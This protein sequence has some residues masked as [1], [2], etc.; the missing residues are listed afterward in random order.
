[1]PNPQFLEPVS[2]DDPCGPD[3]RWDADFLALDNGLSAAVAQG[4][5]TVVAGQVVETA[6]RAYD[7]LVERAVALSA[8]TKDLRVLATYAEASWRHGGLVAFAEAMEDLAG[9]VQQWPGAADG[10]HPRAD[11]IDG[12]LGERA[13]ALGK[14]LHQIPVLVPTVGWGGHAS[15]GE[16]LQSAATLR[17]V[18]DAWT[19]RMGGAFG[20]ELPSAGDAWSSLRR[21]VGGVPAADGDADADA[22]AVDGTVSPPPVDA[23]D[24]IDQAL[25]RM[26]DQDHHSPALPLLRMLSSWRSLG[27]IDIVDRMK[28]SGVTLE[29]LMESVK[30][31]TQTE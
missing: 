22:S 8:R 25:E 3:L 13:A 29:Q 12:D 5:A 28:T 19:E 6:D 17:G 27:I 7:D 10:V 9:V 26:V 20:A 16:R 14:L 30:R 24:L 1:M 21:L 31:Q 18:F 2:E 23:W 11:E 4:Q 15:D